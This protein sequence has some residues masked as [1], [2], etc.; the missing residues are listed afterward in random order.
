MVASFMAVY[1]STST[2]DARRPRLAEVASV[3]TL[4]VRARFFGM[5]ATPRAQAWYDAIRAFALLSLLLEALFA[6]SVFASSFDSGPYR[7]DLPDFI[8]WSRAFGLLWVVAFVAVALDRIRMARVLAALAFVATIAGTVTT[9]MAVR[10]SGGI[11]DPLL[12]ENFVPRLVSPAELIL[13]AWL[14]VTLVALFGPAPNVH[15]SPRLWLGLYLFG[16]VIIVGEALNVY[17]ATARGWP[18]TQVLNP[19]VIASGGLVITL[20]VA[21]GR[22][23]RGRERSPHWLLVLSP[24]GALIGAA[25]LLTSP[26]GIRIDARISDG[27][28]VA[29]GILTSVSDVAL[30]ALALAAAVVSVYLLRRLNAR[31]AAD[32]DVGGGNDDQGRAIG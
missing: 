9:N 18:W 26:I 10:L 12:G 16:A 27:R 32:L 7:I 22:A 31:S 20:A 13:M 19:E 4:A 15:P 8:V 6:T 29:F 25:K 14:A 24:I 21:L 2:A 17:E 30:V 5:H 1:G 23:L 3:V 28:Q 11:Y